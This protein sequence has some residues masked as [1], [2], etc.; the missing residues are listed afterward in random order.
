MGTSQLW[1]QTAGNVGVAQ[2]QRRRIIKCIQR[3]RP[4]LFSVATCPM[5][6]WLLPVLLLIYLFIKRAARGKTSDLDGGPDG[7]APPIACFPD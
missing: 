6:S 5:F 2:Q 7:A 4:L 1:M 3:R